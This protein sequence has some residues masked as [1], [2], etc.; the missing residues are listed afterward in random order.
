MHST[1]A[2]RVREDERVVKTFLMESL[3]RG[4]VLLASIVFIM[5]VG[6]LVLMK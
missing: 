2:D 1:F 5:I 4:G 6:V 3:L